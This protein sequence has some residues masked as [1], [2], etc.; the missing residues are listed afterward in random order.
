MQRI[1]GRQDE[2]SM[3]QTSDLYEKLCE[4]NQSDYYGFHM[5]GH[6]RNTDIAGID[7]PYGI[8]IT[9]IDGFDDLHH[10]DGIL[11]EAQERAARVYGADE[12]RFL[13]NGSTVGILSAILG[14]T[15]KGDRI[16]VARHCHKSVYHAICLN[17]LRPCYL[18]P[19]FQEEI[20]LN[21][22]I[23]VSAVKTALMEYSDIR[24]VVIVSPT[25]DGVISDV[26]QI[27]EVVHEKG[28][29]LIVDEA[30]GAHLGFHPYF[31]GNALSKGA[32][33]VIHSVHKT[34]PSLTQTALLHVRGELADRRRIFRYLDMLQSSS[35]SY[36]L[37]AGIDHC[38]RMLEERREEL[39]APYA[40]RL[41]RL[42][43]DLKALKCLELLE[44][45]QYDRS[46]LVISTGVTGMTGKELYRILLD[47][48][49][50]Q[51]EM[52]AGTYVIAMTSVADTEEGFERLR[53]ALFEI[54][55]RIDMHRGCE[56]ASG[57]CAGDLPKAQ[58]VNAIVAEENV[59]D[60]DILNRLPRN[61]QVMPIA[62]GL[63]IADERA[64][65]HASVRVNWQQSEGMIAAEYAY[66][67]PPGSPLIVPGERISSEAVRLIERYDAAGFSIEGPERDGQIEVIE[68]MHGR[69]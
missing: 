2:Q 12:T 64:R 33:V 61:K 66:L 50:L 4:Y 41:A 18:Y 44:T 54:D 37:M 30:H 3:I 31:P 39:F 60:T 23:S 43:E 62:E 21:T 25:Y 42:R 45:R 28:I 16:L 68:S 8:D 24:A 67:Y 20:H 53:R 35:P 57:N 14:S 56:E 36:V 48:Y 65:S 63:V 6:K 22:E 19:E 7:L 15:G 40:E 13:V 17:E 69:R 52:A 49:H 58:A 26:E 55:E 29:P 1:F 34:L 27:A 5:P 38:I 9:E 46:K 10:A 47:E 51:M 11:R 32:D 59:L